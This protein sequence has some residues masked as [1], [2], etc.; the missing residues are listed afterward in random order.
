MKN[1]PDKMTVL[2]TSRLILRAW[3]DE[4]APVLFRLARDP[5]IG[6][7]AGFPPHRSEE[8]SLYVIRHILSQPVNFAVVRTV[9]DAV[10][11][12]IGYLFSH[13]TN[14]EMK[15]GEVELGYWIGFDYQRQGYATEAVGALLQYAFAE[16]GCPRVWCSSFPG[17][18]ASRRVQ[19]KCGFAFHHNAY[20]VPMVQIASCRDLRYA[21]ISSEMY[22][23]QLC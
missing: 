2:K 8:D 21:V 22:E 11:G 10:I 12:S 20:G 6:E 9:D 16:M 17:N 3:R 1:I 4:D 13:E 5:R 19:E 15:P 23:E 18:F 14:A 7:A